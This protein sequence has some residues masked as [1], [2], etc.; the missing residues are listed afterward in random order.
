MGKS[1]RVR[2]N[3]AHGTPSVRQT[4]WNRTQKAY[5]VYENHTNA[6]PPGVPP[7]SPTFKVGAD[8]INALATVSTWYSQKIILDRINT[9]FAMYT[10]GA[11]DF[12]SER[13]RFMSKAWDDAQAALG[14]DY[15]KESLGITGPLAIASL[16]AV[17]LGSY[18][19]GMPHAHYLHLPSMTP[20][21]I[22]PMPA[23]GILTIGGSY[24]SLI[25]GR[26][27]M[28]AGDMGL[29]TCFGIPPGMSI[30]TGSSNV[31]IGGGRAAR[32]CDIVNYCR[33]ETGSAGR[34]R[35]AWDFVMRLLWVGGTSAV[36]LGAFLDLGMSV[37][38]SGKKTPEAAAM[39]SALAIAGGA[40]AAQVAADVAA[41]AFGATL[42]KD[43]CNP[44]HPIGMVIGPG[45]TV[46]IGG[47]PMP[48]WEALFKGIFS[49]LKAGRRVTLNRLKGS[50][51]GTTAN[52]TSGKSVNKS[53]KAK[54]N[55]KNTSNKNKKNN[56][57]NK[58]NNKGP[59]NSGNK[60]RTKGGPRF[61]ARFRKARMNFNRFSNRV[62]NRAGK[63]YRSAVKHGKKIT[64]A[65]INAGKKA[66]KAAINAGKKAAKATVKATKWVV[67]QSRK[68]AAK[69]ANMAKKVAKYA[70]KQASNAAKWTRRQAKTVVTKVNNTV[71]RIKNGLSN[72][73]KGKHKTKGCPISM[74]TG[75]ELL[76]LEDFTI[77]GSLP[78]TFERVYRTGHDENSGMG[79]G[80]T[81]TGCQRLVLGDDAWILHHSDGRQVWFS[82]VQLGEASFN[83]REKALLTYL[84][85]GLMRL[86]I[87][88]HEWV[89]EPFP[90]AWLV[91]HLVDRFKNF[92]HFERDEYGRWLACHGDHG[93]GF[94]V[95]WND[96]GMI[97]GFIP[98]GP[99]YQQAA[100]AD[101]TPE[102]LP[103]FARYSYD[104]ELNMTAAF[105]RVN[106]CERYD[107][108]NHVLT[109]R[110]L[111]TGFSFYFEWDRHDIHARC[112][113]TW[114]DN[115][116]YHYRF[117]WD[118]EKRR[119]TVTNILGNKESVHWD[120]AGQIIA[121]CD[122][123]G[124]TTHFDYDDQGNLLAV[125]DP[126]GRK[127]EY[128]YDNAG[129]L[130]EVTDAMGGSTLL[131]Y[132]PNGLP[133]FIQDRAGHAW[134]TEY[135]VR[136]AE[137]ATWDP[138][139]QVTL[140]ENDRRGNRTR[141]TYADGTSVVLHWNSAGDNV[142]IEHANGSVTRQ[143]FNSDGYLIEQ[144]QPDGAVHRFEHDAMGR[145]TREWFPDGTSESFFWTAGDD[146]WKHRDR[147]GRETRYDFAGLRQPQSQTNP[148]GTMI[149]YHYD[150][151]RNLIRLDNEEGESMTFAY[152]AAENLME[153]VGFDGRR[154]CFS[155]DEA[156]RLTQ[157]VEP[158]QTVIHY[159]YDAL[160]QLTTVA[161]E[162]TRGVSQPTIR[163][164]YDLAG[165][166][167]TALNSERH[168]CFRYDA[169]GNLIEEWQDDEPL[170][171]HYDA[172][173]NLIGK[174]LPNGQKVKIERD[175]EGDWTALYLENHCLAAVTRDRLGQEQ[176]RHFGNGLI[177]RIEY[178]HTGR[179]SQ[180]RVHRKHLQWDLLTERR[181]DYDQVGN[182]VAR[183]DSKRGITRFCYDRA[184]FPI[185]VLQ[186]PALGGDLGLAHDGAGNISGTSRGNR[187]QNLE[188]RCYAY[189]ARGNL[190][191]RRRGTTQVDTTT[192]EYNAFDQMIACTH[193]GRRTT[194]GYDALGR[195]I[196]KT[197]ND[198]D[199]LF[200]W[201]RLSLLME[202]H[203]DNQRW[204]FHEPDSFVP[205][206]ATHGDNT[207]YFHVDP[208]GTPWEVTD[209]RCRLQW[210]AS[211]NTWGGTHTVEV[212][213]FDNPFRLQ[214]QYFDAESGLH[215]NLNRYYDP[216]NGRFCSQ[217]PI[218]LAGGL[219]A[220]LYA[221]NTT[222]WIDPLGFCK[223]KIRQKYDAYKKRKGDKA[224]DFQTWHQKSKDLAER[225]ARYSYWKDFFK[226]YGNMPDNAK[227]TTAKMVKLTPELKQ[228]I[229]HAGRRIAG[230]AGEKPQIW[231]YGG[232]VDQKVWD[233][234][235][236]K[237]D[238]F[239]F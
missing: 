56:N 238:I 187:L 194:Y 167:I 142:M 139:D 13:G 101:Q 64:K 183:E 112:L 9:P 175:R 159:E 87:D 160:D 96:Q 230:K 81:Y 6:G 211:Y 206:A 68:V 74:I 34:L 3:S 70:Q 146:I 137:V 85:H 33:H 174:E 114:G 100:F 191:E 117:T 95:Q 141:T 189:D 35:Q 163:Y 213:C 83:T 185:R 61:R 180:Q 216:D 184:D 103:P 12:F 161:A 59:K 41:A 200:Y 19:A 150:G 106:A 143:K 84:D 210:S 14:L 23:F 98:A 218:G 10:K 43:P 231:V 107:Y 79:V 26:P 172:V 113:A 76:V 225:K 58:N 97:A 119:S 46:K 196:R 151:E 190:I 77:R 176:E 55:K 192:F 130:V 148:D 195:R 205:L 92:Y 177:G 1:V 49:V 45:S 53:K 69:T 201:D 80:W 21:G 203:E 44:M 229:N 120:E 164:E 60:K 131:D 38:E 222:R 186:P 104:N 165:N 108:R 116:C 140:F 73:A 2:T 153:R 94:R 182:L 223:E 28:R 22:I 5:T 37:V 110:T 123:R 66:T 50:N 228:W 90:S 82:P 207:Y 239:V 209:A 71:S 93:R 118:L 145:L 15:F 124:N 204:F 193:K 237:V 11:A 235:K 29:T 234:A 220:Y 67:R 63:A 179:I 132:H 149:R 51:K 155:Y 86:E 126:L 162:D 147:A 178:D 122:G 219:N 7:P 75:E 133:D 217:D 181:F 208:V 226:K 236:G 27:A 111:K 20:A 169:V 72:I 171:F 52:G 188:D 156:N 17:A 31:F 30:F 115:G 128:A 215:Y 173:G 158:G 135:S 138:N 134:L 212:G 99:W 129:R 39:S 18:T 109:R 152:D 154:H 57:N 227:F 16:D 125:T 8:A 42:G 121:E 102:S 136:G 170:F 202:E 54:N 233:Y 47:F 48:A 224:M 4:Y 36:A 78:F 214:G 166:L 199:T 197:T 157:R 40:A 32:T 88:G 91:T 62:R 168:L 127:T 198:E 105:D 144:I 221:P 89:M 24:Q 232:Q 25:N 65:A